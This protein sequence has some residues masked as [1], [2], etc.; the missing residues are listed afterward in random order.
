MHPLRQARRQLPGHVQAGHDPEILENA[1][2]RQAL[3]TRV[4]T[5]VRLTDVPPG[6]PSLPWDISSQLH[7]SPGGSCCHNSLLLA[8]ELHSA[9]RLRLRHQRCS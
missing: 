1:V 9:S 4:A 6:L 8:M 7:T 2:V 3:G 5:A